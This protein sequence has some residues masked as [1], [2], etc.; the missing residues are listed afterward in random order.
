MSKKSIKILIIILA[1]V[2]L[3]AISLILII[4]RFNQVSD[5]HGIEVGMDADNIKDSIAEKF[6]YEVGKYSFYTNENGH[7]VVAATDPQTGLIQSIKTFDKAFISNKP[8]SFRKIKAGMDV[9]DVVAQVG[10]P[11]AS[12][13]DGVFALEFL[14]DDE[15]IYLVYFSS[16]ESGTDIV[17]SVIGPKD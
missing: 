11:Y 2:I 12:R 4:P 10:L 1:A 14:S 3:A 9:M 5:T 7:P 17:H 16:D 8:D 6:L 13:T 15:Q